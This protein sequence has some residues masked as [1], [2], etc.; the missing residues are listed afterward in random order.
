MFV[1][2]VFDAGLSLIGVPH[3]VDVEMGKELPT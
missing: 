2:V 3:G 1:M